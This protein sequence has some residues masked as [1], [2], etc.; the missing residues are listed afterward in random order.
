[1]KKLTKILTLVLALAVVTLTALPVNAASYNYT[2]TV[3]GG[4]HGSSNTTSY[5]GLAYGSRVEL[6]TP[7]SDDP[8]YYAKGYAISGTNT[9][10]STGGYYK[11]TGDEDL[12]VLYASKS[13]NMV[14]YTIKY[15][16]AEGNELHASDTFEGAVGD[17]PVVAYKYID[18]YTPRDAYSLTKTLS[19]NAADNVFT[20][21]YV[22]GDN[23]TI[24]VNDGTYAVITNVTEVEGTDATLDAGTAGAGTAGAAGADANAAEENTDN[25]ETIE[26]ETTPQEVIDLDDEEIPLAN[27]QLDNG[28]SV[29]LVAGSV[30]GVAAIAA[31][32]AA[33]VAKKK[34]QA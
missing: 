12:V 31:I 33:V 30:V 7:V 32:I 28:V 14:N 26:D 19:E 20:F 25:G 27:N 18:G 9:V 17:K 23:S 11:V 15:Q 34:K 6:K 4:D 22:K 2:I 13:S 10:V 8:E 5:T 29:P 21:V 16:D 24:I 1:M 3:T